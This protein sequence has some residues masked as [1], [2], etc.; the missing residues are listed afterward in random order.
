[1]FPYRNGGSTSRSP[2]S[3]SS[4]SPTGNSDEAAKHSRF[5]ATLPACVFC[6]S[7]SLRYRSPRQGDDPRRGDSERH[8]ERIG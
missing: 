4:P 6:C 2:P 1:V 7:V 3:S 5:S 8:H